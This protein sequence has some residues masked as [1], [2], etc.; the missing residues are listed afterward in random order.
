MVRKVS[1]EKVC[2]AL[3][4]FVAPIGAL[5]CVIVL[6]VCGIYPP[7][8]A[9]IPGY[10][11]LLIGVS[12]LLTIGFFVLTLPIWYPIEIIIKMVKKHANKSSV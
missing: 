1:F 2:G 6:A 8:E 12:P 10:V 7:V 4:G 5:Y 11:L 9:L 3:L